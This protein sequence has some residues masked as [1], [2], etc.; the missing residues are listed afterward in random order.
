[1]VIRE[2]TNMYNCYT[3]KFDNLGKYDDYWLQFILKDLHLAD[4]LFVVYGQEAIFAY[5]VYDDHDY[6]HVRVRYY[7]YDSKENIKI[8]QNDSDRFNVFKKC[9]NTG[10]INGCMQ[11]I[12]YV[13]AKCNCIRVLK[14]LWEK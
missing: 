14:L 3:S 13:A 12:D 11:S 5:I 9:L 8:V 6:D 4:L 7:G 2:L 10:L 1:M